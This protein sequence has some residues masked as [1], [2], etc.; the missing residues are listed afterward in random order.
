MISMGVESSA[1]PGRLYNLNRPLP[2]VA[3][4]APCY[5]GVTCIMIRFR[6]DRDCRTVRVQAVYD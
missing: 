1:D 2:P 6:G 4:S 3:F 5:N